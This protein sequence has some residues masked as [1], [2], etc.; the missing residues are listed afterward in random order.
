MGQ[1][2][3]FEKIGVQYEERDG[4]LYPLITLDGR[5]YK[6]WKIRTHVD[7]IFEVRISTEVSKLAKIRRTETKGSRGK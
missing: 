1:Q 4:L 2:T 5:W 6:C 3:L 7:A